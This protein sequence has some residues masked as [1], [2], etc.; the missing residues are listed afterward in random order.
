MT[1]PLSACVKRTLA[2][3]DKKARVFDSIF[4]NSLSI[5]NVVI[6]EKIILLRIGMEWL[7]IAILF[8]IGIRCVL[9]STFLMQSNIILCLL[10][11]G[12]AKL[13]PSCRKHCMSNGISTEDRLRNQPSRTVVREEDLC[14]GKELGCID[15]K[16]IK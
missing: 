5:G 15:I 2:C 1:L 9:L 14:E 13:P 10:F 11:S 3:S 16:V 7:V 8:S 6:G 12:R 4:N